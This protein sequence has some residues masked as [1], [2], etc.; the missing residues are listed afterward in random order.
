MSSFTEQ[1]LSAAAL[2]DSYIQIILSTHPELLI[3]TCASSN[4]DGG[5][6]AQSQMYQ[7]ERI[8][9]FR[10]QLISQLQKQPIPV[11]QDEH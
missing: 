10:Q 4:D 1:Q 2:A 8:S 6:N 5:P 9:F 11:E 3:P 7:A